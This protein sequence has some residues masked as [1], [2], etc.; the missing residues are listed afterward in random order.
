M[1]KQT[2]EIEMPNPINGEPLP[3]ILITELKM[4]QKRARS[5]PNYELVM[6]QEIDSDKM[7][8]II[9]DKITDTHQKIN[10]PNPGTAPVES[11]LIY[12]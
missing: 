5:S 1:G 6:Q 9:E 8:R 3:G 7:T 12:H 11:T 10:K 2:V 4:E